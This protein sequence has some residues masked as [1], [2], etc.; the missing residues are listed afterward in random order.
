MRA[1]LR[2]RDRLLRDSQP[3][4]D[5]VDRTRRQYDPDRAEGE[6]LQLP[7]D[8]RWVKW[9]PWEHF[10]DEIEQF[11]ALAGADLAAALR[12]ELWEVVGLYQEEK[13]RAGQVDFM[14]LLLFARDLLQRVDLSVLYDHVF[15]DEFQDTDPLQSEILRKVAA[16]LFVVGDPEA[17]HLPLPPRRRAPLPPYSR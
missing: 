15:V 6:L 1:K 2:P 9:E 17:V 5:F 8:M 16:R 4:A 10:K 11:G 3:L 14:D 7:R 12:D 13:R